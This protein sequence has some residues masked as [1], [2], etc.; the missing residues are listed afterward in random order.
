MGA[1][2][3]GHAVVTS[4]A[5]QEGE[6]PV[7]RGPTLVSMMLQ[8]VDPRLPEMSHPGEEIR[9]R[10]SLPDPP[11][12]VLLHSQHIPGGS[13]LPQGPQA[14][15]M[16]QGVW[17]LAPLQPHVSADTAVTFLHGS[18]QGHQGHA[19]RGEIQ[20]NREGNVNPLFTWARGLSFCLSLQRLLYLPVS[21]STPHPGNTAVS[22]S[23]LLSAP[24]SW[25]KAVLAILGSCL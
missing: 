2:P 6:Q 7:S 19:H 5:P 14:P 23:C 25:G 1:G 16:L 18:G 21:S 17:V 20:G 13:H 10:P 3:P 11:L 12:W 15:E 4:A 24:H 9:A 8:Q 22:P